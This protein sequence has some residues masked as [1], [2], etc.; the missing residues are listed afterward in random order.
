MTKKEIEARLPDLTSKFLAK[1]IT[2]EEFIE[3]E[4]LNCREMINSCLCYGE[5]YNFYGHYDKH[6]IK[7]LGEERVKELIAEQTEDFKKATVIRDVHTD[8]EGVSYNR[9]VWADEQE[10]APGGL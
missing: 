5:M 3:Y 10:D 9:V 2:P 4:E 6:Y 1:T 7:T 8:S